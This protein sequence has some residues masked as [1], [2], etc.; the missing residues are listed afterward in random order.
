MTMNFEETKQLMADA[1]SRK[2]MEY[3]VTRNKKFDE[4][5]EV[6]LARFAASVKNVGTRVLDLGS[7]PGNESIQLKR[8]GLSPV[9]ID[10]APGM[11]AECNKKGLK[12]HVM[13]FW[14]LKFSDGSFAGAWMAF[15][16]LHV[17]K[18]DASAILLE[19][20][21]I[22]QPNGIFYVS[23]FEGDG[24]GLRTDDVTRFGC[25][26]YFAYYQREEME[27]LL[28]HKFQIRFASRLD[29]SPRPTISFECVKPTVDG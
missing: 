14:K 23:L 2:A 11:V 29:I 22:L 24:E 28:L 26:R 12:A 6:E 15:S 8:L 18:R 1:Y 7:G 25:E 21:R 19:V 17:P 9:C 5:L 4:F 27:R 16:L 13:D 3:G 20:Y 10:N